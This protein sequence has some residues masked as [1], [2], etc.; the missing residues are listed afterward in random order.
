MTTLQ[1]VIYARKLFAKVGTPPILNTKFEKVKSEL[2]QR[3]REE[4]GSASDTALT[5]RTLA[6]AK[7]IPIY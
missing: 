3:R 2:K 4:E 5:Q 7:N 6:E 1:T